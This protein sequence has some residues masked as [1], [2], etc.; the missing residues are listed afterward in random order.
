[1][2]LALFFKANS[3]F[4]LAPLL[5]QKH[6]FALKTNAKVIFSW[7][8][9][10]QKSIVFLNICFKTNAKSIKRFRFGVKQIKKIK[11]IKKTLIQIPGWQPPF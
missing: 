5:Y 2:T 11:K 9:N 1:M 10:H 6:D 7:P 3:H 4:S 8:Q